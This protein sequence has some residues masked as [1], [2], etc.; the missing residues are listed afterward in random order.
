VLELKPSDSPVP[1]QT[2]YRYVRSRHVLIISRISYNSYLQLITIRYYLQQGHMPYALPS[3]AFTS[4]TLRHPCLL[5]MPFTKLQPR[6]V[7]RLSG[8]TRAATSRLLMDNTFSMVH[9]TILA[10]GFLTS[11]ALSEPHYGCLVALL[12]GMHHAPDSAENSPPQ[13]SGIVSVFQA[14]LIHT[15]HRESNPAPTGPESYAVTKYRAEKSVPCC[16]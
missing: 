5:N 6:F 10:S 1:V 16:K 12:P 13:L 8:P 3:R 2:G 15:L 4:L 7:P 11:S 14:I 9:T